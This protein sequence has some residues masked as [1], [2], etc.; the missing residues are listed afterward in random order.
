MHHLYFI[1]AISLNAATAGKVAGIVASVYTLL[2]V[3]K[4]SFPGVS[5]YGALAINVGLSIGGVAILLPPEKLFSLESLTSL[6]V[7]G[8]SAAG[9]AGIHGTVQNLTSV[10][11]ASAAPTINAGANVSASSKGKYDLS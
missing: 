4:K 1:A 11:Q 5:G 7:A 8:I 6:L 10:N 2:Q 9:A 3:I